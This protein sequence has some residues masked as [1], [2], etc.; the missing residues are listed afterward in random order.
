VSARVLLVDDDGNLRRVLA[1]HLQTAGYDVTAKADGRGALE[2]LE[3][4]EVDLLLTDVRMPG[5]DGMALLREVRRLAPDLPVLVMTAY[6]TIQDAVDAMK[7]GAFD[8]LTKPVERDTLLRAVQKG[9]QFGDLRRENR[10]LRASL[11][12]QHPL[13]TIL[14]ASA[15]MEGVRGL[16]RKAGPTEATVL[17]TGESGTGKELV[18]RAL[19]ALSERAGGPFVALNC[20]ALSAE[21]LESEL[22]GHAR[23]AFTGAVA[24]HP[25]KFRQAQG[26]TLFL[27]EIGDMDPR[28]QAKILRALQ[29]RVVDPVGSTKPVPVNVRLLAASNRDLKGAAAEGSFREDLYYRLAVLTVSL[30]PLREREGDALL[31]MKHFCRQETGGEL[32]LAPES[33]RLIES[34]GWPGN[35]RELANLCQ[36][37]AILYPR[38]RITPEMLPSEIAVGGSIPAGV[39][40]PGGGLW[41]QERAAIV[42]ALREHGG[43][44]S[45]AARAL[46]VPRHILLYRLKKYGLG[47]E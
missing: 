39:V 6:G 32:N 9:L 47:E 8:Y 20:A 40:E 27:D 41:D 44:R 26:G 16:V 28:L 15:V 25:G 23:G 2:A 45:A 13:D 11:A 3:G 35:V 22:F 29:E 17:I 14:G 46:K 12:E 1:H 37:L 19:H 5:M 21:L 4:V 30:P 34:Y 10:R 42:R 7:E 24:D 43:N 36:K 31:L 18:A 38:Q 33:A